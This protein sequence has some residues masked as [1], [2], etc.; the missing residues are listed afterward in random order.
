MSSLRIHRLDTLRAPPPE[1][2]SSRIPRSEVRLCL[3][4][5]RSIPLSA[6]PPG[7]E[8]PDQVAGDGDRA[9]QVEAAG[10][11]LEPELIGPEA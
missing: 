8:S 9:A 6:P 11:F 2:V 7:E 3:D 4:D 10:R 1:G 5:S